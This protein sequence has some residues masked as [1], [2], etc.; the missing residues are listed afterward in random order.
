MFEPALSGHVFLDLLCQVVDDDDDLLDLL[1]GRAPSIQS[2]IG[3]PWT[4]SNGFGLVS[5]WGRKRVPNPAAR[6]TASI[7]TS[8]IGDQGIR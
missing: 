1:S 5:V 6:I 2:R 4:G 3:R 7:T 8:E